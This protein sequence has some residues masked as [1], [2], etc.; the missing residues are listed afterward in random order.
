MLSSARSFGF[1]GVGK[2]VPMP[3]A[4]SNGYITYLWLS[5]LFGAQKTVIRLGTFG[6]KGA[7]ESSTWPGQRSR[8]TCDRTHMQ[9]NS[10]VRSEPFLSAPAV[11]DQ[12]VLPALRMR[13]LRYCWVCRVCV[14]PVWGV[15]SAEL[16]PT[17]ENKK[18][19]LYKSSRSSRECPGS[20]E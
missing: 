15:P 13:H 12:P 4:A 6:G 3:S 5:E 2:V 20:G 7:G 17:A 16:S 14:P 11:G 1:V 10:G 8:F 19:K 18:G 9:R